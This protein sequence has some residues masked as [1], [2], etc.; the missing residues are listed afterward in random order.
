[1]PAAK[2]SR[3]LVDRAFCS[4]AMSTSDLDSSGSAAFWAEPAAGCCAAAEAAIP[5]NRNRARAFFMTSSP[6]FVR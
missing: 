1:M 3:R 2:S 5:R 6:S 4:L